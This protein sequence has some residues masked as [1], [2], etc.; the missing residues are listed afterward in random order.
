MVPDAPELIDQLLSV[1]LRLGWRVAV[2]PNHPG[3]MIMGTDA[4]M[5]AVQDE[6]TGEKLQVY[7]QVA[8]LC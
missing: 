1:A 3:G 8:G 4:Y 2:L 6:L 7:E 5:N